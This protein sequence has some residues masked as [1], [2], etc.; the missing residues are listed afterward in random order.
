MIQDTA[1]HSNPHL[2]VSGE[3]V[4]QSF[5]TAQEFLDRWIAQDY[6]GTSRIKTT[7]ED[8]A[9]NHIMARDFN[10][11][12]IAQAKQMLD[13]AFKA[14]KVPHNFQPGKFVRWKK[15]MKNR[16]LPAYGDLAIVVEVLPTP[17]YD[18]KSAG[19]SESPLFHEPLDLILGVFA[20]NDEEFLLL[21]YDS[22]RFEPF[23]L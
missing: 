8:C 1:G 13:I 12:E 2:E 10:E 18:R 3:A 4:M 6:R 17:V 5:R 7:D 22:R 9:A 15:G 23:P 16:K 14:L 11:A 21:H 20:R 19:E